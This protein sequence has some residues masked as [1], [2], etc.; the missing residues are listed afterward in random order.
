MHGQY[1]PGANIFREMAMEIGKTISAMAAVGL[2]AGSQV[3]GAASVNEFN[4][5][6]VIYQENHSFDNL[7]GLWGEVNGDAVH[8]LPQA[9]AA[10]TTQ[11]R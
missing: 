7:Y 5:I 8:G 6:V 2:I 4:H 11:V 9:D 10:H 3:A 1:A